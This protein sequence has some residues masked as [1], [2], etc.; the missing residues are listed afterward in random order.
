MLL[1]CPSCASLLSVSVR[2]LRQLP[3]PLL[4]CGQCHQQIL[5]KPR[6]AKCGG[7]Q[8]PITYYDYKLNPK[9][10]LMDCPS[11]KQVNRMPIGKNTFRMLKPS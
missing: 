9:R 8:E 2:V 1:K 11:C 10:P 5:V 4:N 6:K 3:Q 7:C